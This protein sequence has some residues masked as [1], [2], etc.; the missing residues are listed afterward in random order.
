M[1]LVLPDGYQY[2]AA[3]LLSASWVIIWQIIRI[4]PARRAAG[5]PYPQLYAE[6]AQLKE[7]P[8]ALRYNCVQRCHQNTL[9]NIPLIMISRVLARI[10]YTIGYS[11]GVPE[12]R[13]AGS[14]SGSLALMGLLAAAT[15]TI[16]QVCFF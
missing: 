14:A 6:N 5:I 12:K 11:T 3:S 10:A 9:E 1:T 8:A 15:V 16:V 7:N 4:G 2:V 13:A